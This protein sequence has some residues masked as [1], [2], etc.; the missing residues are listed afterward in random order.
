MRN[1]GPQLVMAPRS[2]STP[3]MEGQSA[4]RWIT[5]IFFSL[6]RPCWSAAL[7]RSK[8]PG[9]WNGEPGVQPAI[10][11]ENSPISV[12]GFYSLYGR[13]SYRQIS[14]SLKD[15]R[16]DAIIIASPWNLTDISAA[17]LPSCLS[18]AMAIEKVSTRISQHKYFTRP[19][20]KAPVR[21]VSRGHGSE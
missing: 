12:Q 15:A 3:C 8:E 11:T 5:G 20:G 1:K 16:L 13:K 21:L 9:T 19:C 2:L 17:L 10:H 7:G 6:T 4:L 18:N 14:G